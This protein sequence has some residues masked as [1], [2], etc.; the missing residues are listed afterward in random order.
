MS[1]MKTAEA[2]QLTSS[3]ADGEPK[4]VDTKKL[5]SRLAYYSASFPIG[6]VGTGCKMLSLWL[7]PT[8]VFR[9]V[10]E[11]EIQNEPIN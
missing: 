11:F 2:I 4:H 7:N 10:S 3:N 6:S 1:S 9:G 5:E 8:V